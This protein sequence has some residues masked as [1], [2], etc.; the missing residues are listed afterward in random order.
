MVSTIT[1]ILK[2]QKEKEE[3]VKEE[4]GRKEGRKEEKKEREREK[5]RKERKE[6]KKRKKERRKKERKKEKKERKKERRKE[7]KKEIEGKKE[8]KRRRKGEIDGVREG[9]RFFVSWL[10]L[11]SLPTFSSLLYGFVPSTLTSLFPEHTIC[12]QNVVPG[13]PHSISSSWQTPARHSAPVQIHLIRGLSSLPQASS[14][15]VFLSQRSHAHTVIISAVTCYGSN[16][17]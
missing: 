8:R 13:I 7:R 16:W 14:C 6:R 11:I 15:S 1:F 4:G 3:G 2:K 9:G 17:F 5:G 10:Q 12:F